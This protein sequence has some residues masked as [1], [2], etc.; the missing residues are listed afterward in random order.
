MLNRFWFR[1]K[2]IFPNTQGGA[3]ADLLALN[4]VGKETVL[5]WFQNRFLEAILL[6]VELVGIWVLLFLLSVGRGCQLYSVPPFHITFF[7]ALGNYVEN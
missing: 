3:R 6:E 4:L 5:D 1:C 7:P 2:R